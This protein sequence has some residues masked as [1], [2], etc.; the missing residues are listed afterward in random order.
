MVSKPREVPFDPETGIEL[1]GIDSLQRSGH[2]M[3]A[4]KVYV[5][6]VWQ[7]GDETIAL[8]LIGRRLKTVNGYKTRFPEFA[9]EIEKALEHHRAIARGDRA[10]GG[11]PMPDEG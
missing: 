11:V 9:A 3:Q 6:E 7:H 5:H 2:M 10:T 8:A 4:M 1:R